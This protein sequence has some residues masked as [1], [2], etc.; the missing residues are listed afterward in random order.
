MEEQQSDKKTGPV[1]R[2]MLHL[3][4]SRNWDSS[5]APPTASG[6]NG[7]LTGRH[8]ARHGGVARLFMTSCAS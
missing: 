3:A 5:G 7:A 1:R 8:D 4:R 6:R 2:M